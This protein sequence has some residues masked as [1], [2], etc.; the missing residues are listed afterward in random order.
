MNRK[1][2]IYHSCNPHSGYSRWVKGKV[3]VN[4]LEE[5]DILWVDG[6]ADIN[7]SLYG[8]KTHKSTWGSSSHRDTQ[9][10]SD[11]ERAIQ[12]GKYIIGTCRGLQAL[13]VA[14]KGALIQDIYHPGSHKITT[15]D[16]KELISSSL[17]H[18]LIDPTSI[19]KDKLKVLAWAANLSPYHKNGDNEEVN[20]EV[21]PEIAYYP[22][23]KGLGWQGHPEMMSE[24]SPMVKY[25]QELINKLINN[26]L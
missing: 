12:L 2:K 7:A 3:L 23:I 18:Q 24:N 9:E 4:S 8:Q 17:H 20:I 25:C 22:E 14:S 5:A 10:F 13:Q 26:E 19:S 21:E 6:G 1:L 11:I 15:Y 16:G